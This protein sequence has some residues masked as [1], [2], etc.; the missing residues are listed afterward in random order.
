MTPNADDLAKNLAALTERFAGLAAKL[1]QAAQE[2]QT[3]GT[4]PAEALL[5]ELAAA[6][7][8]FI[9]L[10]SSVL[11]AARARALTAPPQAEV[12]SLKALEP[13]LQ[14]VAAAGA[15]QVQV[16]RTTLVE[17]RRRVLAVLDRVMT[18]NHVDDPN[19]RSE[20]RRVGKECRSRWAPY[21]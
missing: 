21:R 10:R 13:V 14:A 11:D 3:S 6:R 1:I 8:A 12:G 20:E 4:L 15:T 7:G 9:D 17:A 19:F 18:I 5:E 2:L 16:Q